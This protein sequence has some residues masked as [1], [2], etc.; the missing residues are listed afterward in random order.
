MEIK[1]CVD[2]VPYTTKP[3]N[4]EIGK[5]SNRIGKVSL[6]TTDDIKMFADDVGEKGHT[7]CPATF[8]GIRNKKNFEQF[9]VI[10]LDF[11]DGITWEQVKERA[12]KYNLPVLFA[13]ET[14]SSVNCDKFRVVFLNDASIPYTKVAETIIAALRVIFP[15]SDDNCTDVSRM[16]F[17]GKN[18]FYYD[19]TLPKISIESLVMNM[20]L[21][22]KD[23][24]GAN[25]YG[26]EMQ[27]FATTTRVALESSTSLAV[28]TYSNKDDY[29]HDCIHDNTLEK[30]SPFVISGDI[31]RNGENFSKLYKII[32]DGTPDGLPRN[33]KK[34]CENE[35]HKPCRIPLKSIVDK[36]RLLREFVNGDIWLYH[37]QLVG[38]GMNLVYIEGGR[39][40][41]LDTLKKHGGKYSSYPEKYRTFGSHFLS[42]FV[43]KSYSPEKCEH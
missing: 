4:G 18:L 2:K 41:F 31:N 32:F 8:K 15:E 20:E 17:G 3:E 11:D 40:L 30:I 14:F 10:A 6:N 1:L 39:K 13:Y 23:T 19:E 12:D 38:L 29:I 21:Y 43:N 27:K 33:I 36:C 24:Y 42:Y 25:N 28:Y 35:S 9:Q 16:F 34:C 7:W 37:H 22:L 26:R 5:I